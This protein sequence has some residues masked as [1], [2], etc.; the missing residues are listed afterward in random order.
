MDP[1]LVALD[2]DTVAQARNLA[3][4]LRGI[5]G[6]FKIG[7]R[8][9]T[10]GGPS[11]VE[12]LV[13]NGDRVFLDLKFHDIPNTVA[14]AVAAAA[15]L[16][17]WMLNVHASGGSAMMRAARA[18]ADEEA[19]RRSRPAPLVIAVTML[20]SFDQQA[21][22]EIGLHASVADQVGRLAALTEA[23]GLDGVV[24]SPQEIDIIRRRCGARFAIVTPGIR[25][26][27]DKRGD[28]SRTMSAPEALVAGATYLVIGRPILEAADARAAAEKIAAD[29]RRVYAS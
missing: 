23:A 1:L 14:G 5:V 28:Q 13:S 16:G 4:Q 20:T 6:G 27:S 24:A 7:S 15:R 9:F 8:L 18:A 22:T 19:A 26:V 2:V 11:L 3:N 29:C 21:L 25:G 10:S 17:V 12:E